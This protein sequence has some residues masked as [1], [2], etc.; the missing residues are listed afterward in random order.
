VKHVFWKATKQS[1]VLAQE[2]NSNVRDKNDHET[3][4]TR[5]KAVQSRNKKENTKL[6]KT[7]VTQQDCWLTDH[8]IL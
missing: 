1:K 4:V 3:Q 8:I 6:I 2:T 5:N 7:L